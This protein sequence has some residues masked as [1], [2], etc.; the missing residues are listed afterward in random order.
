MEKFMYIVQV[1]E[2]IQME[3]FSSMVAALAFLVKEVEQMSQLII[4][5]I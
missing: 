4:M 2:L 5:G 1:M 3:M